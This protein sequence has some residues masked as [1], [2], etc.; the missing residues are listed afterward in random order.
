M[1]VE[2]FHQ[3]GQ[4]FLNHFATMAPRLATKQYLVNVRQGNKGETLGDEVKVLGAV[5]GLKVNTKL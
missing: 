2:S 1:S 5:G 3:L 4:L